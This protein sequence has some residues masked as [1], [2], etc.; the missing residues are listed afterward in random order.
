MRNKGNAYRILAEEPEGKRPVIRSRLGWVYN[1]KMHVRERERMGGMDWVNKAQDRN[2]W[3]TLVSTVL[4]IRVSSNIVEFLCG[5]ATGAFSRMAQL[6][7]ELAILRCELDALCC[8]EAHLVA[9]DYQSF[10]S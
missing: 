4:N 7:L 8:K 6:G 9:I 3:R 2:E 10:L 5:R 1:I